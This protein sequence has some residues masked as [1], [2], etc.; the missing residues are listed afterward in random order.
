MK[1]QE[2]TA[3]RTRQ[4]LYV[5]PATLDRQQRIAGM[6]NQLAADDQQPRPATDDEKAL[7][8]M[9]FSNMKRQAQANYAKRLRQQL[10]N[11]EGASR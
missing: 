1:I 8:F 2:V 5:Q 7:A 9:Q 10:A 11:V 4:V 3:L 6:V